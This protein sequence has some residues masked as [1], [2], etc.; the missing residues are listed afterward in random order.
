[1]SVTQFHENSFQ[2]NLEQSI[3]SLKVKDLK[4]GDRFIVYSDNDDWGDRPYYIFIKMDA[5]ESIDRYED[6]IPMHWNAI[7]ECNGT[8]S[9]MPNEM[10]VLKVE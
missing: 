2:S 8:L 5:V 1:M 10:N 9:E 7:K 6:E 4:R 3:H